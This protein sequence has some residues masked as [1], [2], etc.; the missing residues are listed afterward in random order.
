VLD[1]E[2]E[3]G[4][5][6]GGRVTRLVQDVCEAQ[7]RDALLDGDDLGELKIQAIELTTPMAVMK[8][9]RRARERTTSRNPR[10]SRPRMPVIKPTW[11]VAMTEIATASSSGCLG[12]LCGSPH[13]RSLIS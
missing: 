12:V 13:T 7:E 6:E 5:G 8:P 4:N 11:N 2:D 3:L 10:R 1:D 9:R